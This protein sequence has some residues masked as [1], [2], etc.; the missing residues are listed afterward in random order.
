MGRTAA[1][2][3]I[4][5]LSHIYV[6]ST[7]LNVIG[8]HV[9]EREKRRQHPIPITIRL[10]LIGPEL[11][12]SVFGKVFAEATALDHR[13]IILLFYLDTDIM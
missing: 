13:P 7:P 4:Y 11:A 9:L 10:G 1:P 6:Q 8:D 2:S 5:Q 12:F 3:T